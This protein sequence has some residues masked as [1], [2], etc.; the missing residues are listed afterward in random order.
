ML[1]RGIELAPG[2]LVTVFDPRDLYGPE[3][4]TDLALALSYADVEIVGKGAHFAALPAARSPV[5]RGA[6]ARYRHLDRIEGAA[7]LARR[8]CL[9]RIGIDRVLRIEEGRP[10]LACADGCGQI[11]SADP[12]NYLRFAGAEVSSEAVAACLDQRGAITV[13]RAEVMI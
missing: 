13:G 12:Y 11:Y 9:D 7:W 6:D 4:I 8:A 10:V 1:R 2:P 3:F 5:L